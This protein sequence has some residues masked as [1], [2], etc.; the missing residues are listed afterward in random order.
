MIYFGAKPQQKQVQVS[1]VISNKLPVSEFGEA[2]RADGFLSTAF[3]HSQT[4]YVPA[5]CQASL[6][7]DTVSAKM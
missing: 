2:G 3:S 4:P 7:G 1:M 6:T 5:S